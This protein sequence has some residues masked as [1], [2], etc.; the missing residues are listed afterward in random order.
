M[1]R[2]ILFIAFALSCDTPLDK[3][4]VLDLTRRLGPG[5]VLAGQITQEAALFGGPSAEGQHG[6]F[7]IYN[8]RVRFVIQA[9]RSSSYYVEYGGGILDADMVR[10]WGQPGQDML[11]EHAVMAGFGR[12]L[13][14]ETVEVINDGTNGQAAIIRAT[15]QGAPMQLLSG[16]VESLSIIPWREVTI[17]TD[18]ILAPDSWLLELETTVWW[19]DQATTISTVDLGFL[20]DEVS[21]SYYPGAGLGSG[22]TTFGW[23]GRVG[24]RNEIALA[25]MQGEGKFVANAMLQSISNMAPLLLGTDAKVSLSDGDVYT[26][27]RYMG[28]GPD[29]ATLTDA[30]HEA[31]GEEVETIGGSVTTSGSV[32]SGARVHVLDESGLPITMAITGTDGTWSASVP[33][34]TATLVQATGRGPSVHYDLPEGA[35]WYGPYG[36]RGVRAATL[37]AMNQGARPV[38]FAEGYGISAQAAGSANTPLTL[39]KPGTLSVTIEDGGPAVVRVDFAAG[40]PENADSNIWPGRPSGAMAWLYI[41]DGAGTVPVEPG[42][43]EVVVHR[44]ARYL[45]HV[46]TIEI[47][48]G[49]TVSISAALAPEIVRP[50]VYTG[51]PHAHAGPSGDG[52]IPMEGRLVNHA[53]H[54]IDIHFG[55]DH[56]N[57]ADYRP[58][59]GPLNLDGVLASVTAVEVSPVLRGHFNAYPLEEDRSAPSNGALAWWRT[60]PEWL[61]TDGLF[62]LIRELPSD[63]EVLI[64]ANHSTG[65]GGLYGAADYDLLTGGVSNPEM[66][67]EN[68]DAMELLNNGYHSD[69]LTHY[70]DVVSRG[71]NPTPVGVSDSHSHRGG[72]GSNFTYIPL[73][74]GHISEF[75]PDHIRTAWRDGSTVPSTG[76]LIEARVNGRWAPGQTFSGPTTI[77]LKVWATDFMPIDG[78]QVYRDGEIIQTIPIDGDTPLPISTKI[79]LDPEADAAYVFEVVSSEDMYPVY[80]GEYAWAMTSAIR[81]DV[82]GGDW[83]PPLPSIRAD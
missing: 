4:R 13:D 47:A 44:G 73:P 82:D 65:G 25:L 67:S 31:R 33:A 57:I 11:D 21:E 70:M 53:A 22:P 35:G 12:L 49:Q 51:D 76:P 64:Q 61:T 55:T 6:D 63:G 58:L 7:K 42:S 8:D 39:T 2:L 18:Y 32:V 20:G 45:P 5:Q 52:R 71:L 9:P 37:Q 27:N 16:A 83:T 3:I 10:A 19:H 75:E 81:V 17:Q 59:L 40:D 77:S 62:S 66:W 30:W 50:G 24:Q 54:G 48:S 43:Y 28:I 41:K 14:A 78:L 80:P 38:P 69:Y 72:V 29:L 56:D 36:A 79:T 60:W 68:F 34:G 23:A 46:E 15:G 1:S 74:I 26:W